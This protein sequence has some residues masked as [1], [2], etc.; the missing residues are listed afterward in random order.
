MILKHKYLLIK[1]L[2]LSTLLFFGGCSI[3]KSEIVKVNKFA[4]KLEPTN[5]NLYPGLADIYDYMNELYKTYPKST[6]LYDIGR[7]H[8]NNFIIPLIR[9]GYLQENSTVKYLIVAGTHGD[10]A[11]PVSATINLFHQLLQAKV[12]TKLI[13]KKITVDIIPVLNP[14]GYLENQRENDNGIDINRN[15]PFGNVEVKQESETKALISLIN[16]QNYKASLFLHSANDKKYENL[17]RIPIE[18]NRTGSSALQPDYEDKVLRLSSII[19][20][21]G[22]KTNPYIPYHSSSEM[23]NVTGI[24]SDWCMS[25]VLKKKYRSLIKMKCKYPHPSV[26]IE[27]CYPKQPL[28]KQRIESEQGELLNIVLNV[29]NKF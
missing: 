19:I 16:S 9:I 1:P 21:G 28:N 22:N 2:L 12:L 29:I 11:A 17:V 20:E 10:E 27:L 24:A 18:Y 7:T 8:K 14:E 3:Q 25:G 5:N 23:T 4:H 6:A 15:F 26:T 13:N